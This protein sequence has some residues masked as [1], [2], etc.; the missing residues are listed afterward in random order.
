MENKED[1]TF[2]IRGAI[3]IQ[4]IA[5]IIVA[6]IFWGN[7]EIAKGFIIIFIGIMLVV[8]T[9]GFADIIDLLDSINSKLS[10]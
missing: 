2:F 7:E 10:K 9:K 3:A 5:S 4:I 6:I 8:F 1:K